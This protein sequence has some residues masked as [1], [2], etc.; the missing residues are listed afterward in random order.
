L[1]SSSI[2]A[3]ALLY[4]QGLVLEDMV[5]EEVAIA[6]WAGVVENNATMDSELYSDYE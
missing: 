6:G 2:G 5:G 3:K 4:V 1:N